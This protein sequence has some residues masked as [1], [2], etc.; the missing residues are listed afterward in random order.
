MNFCPYC[1]FDIFPSEWMK[2]WF[3]TITIFIR[4]CHLKVNIFE[5]SRVIFM[6]LVMYVKGWRG[7]CGRSYVD[8]VYW[9]IITLWGNEI[10]LSTMEDLPTHSHP[11][12]MDGHAFIYY[13]FFY[14]FTGL[15]YHWQIERNSPRF[16]L[17]NG[18]NNHLQPRY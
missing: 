11:Q 3:S 9:D 4:L 1:I 13:T 10:S 7:D 18:R 6:P 8:T 5:F 17:R 15:V 2:L 16:S 14:L 12:I